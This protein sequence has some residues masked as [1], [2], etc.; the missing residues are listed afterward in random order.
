[1]SC[2]NDFTSKETDE[3][4]RSLGMSEEEIQEIDRLAKELL[5]TARSGATKDRY[6]RRDFVPSY[7]P[8]PDAGS[9]PGFRSGVSY[10]PRVGEAV[11]VI[12]D[13]NDPTVQSTH[14]HQHDDGD[15][16]STLYRDGRRENYNFKTGKQELDEKRDP[17]DD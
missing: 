7:N 5:T 2:T 6:G 13:D 12:Q 9:I 10:G 1:M 16:I 8:N 15:T 17:I 11:K 14:L 3:C 4:L